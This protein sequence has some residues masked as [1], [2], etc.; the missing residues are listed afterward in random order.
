MSIKKIMVLVGAASMLLL[1]APPATAAPSNATVTAIA[2]SSEAGIL[3]W[4]YYGTYD[5]LVTCQA[6]GI[7]AVFWDG[8]A[9]YHCDGDGDGSYELWVR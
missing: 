2:P 6:A 3:S 5:N 4:R 1:A 9:D 8:Y 7:V